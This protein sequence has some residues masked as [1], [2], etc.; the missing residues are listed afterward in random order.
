MLFS[1]NKE[2]NRLMSKGMSNMYDW[3]K[4]TFSNLRFSRKENL[5]KCTSFVKCK[6]V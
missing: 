5:K 3:E 1:S 6:K 4:L 2:T